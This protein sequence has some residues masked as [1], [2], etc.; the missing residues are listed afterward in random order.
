MSGA[1]DV[2]PQVEP[3]APVSPKKILTCCLL[4]VAAPVGRRHHRPRGRPPVPLLRLCLC[5]CLE[6]PGV[7]GVAVILCLLPLL[8]LPQV[9]LNLLLLL[10]LVILFVLLL[11]SRVLLSCSFAVQ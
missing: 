8:H 11:Q 4:L 9:L 10:P 1:G 3:T 6:V 5:L 7:L 2:P